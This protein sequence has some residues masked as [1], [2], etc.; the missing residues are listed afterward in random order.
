MSLY[1]M[2]KAALIGL[3]KALAREL[4]A[5]RITVNLV[6][7]G[8]VDTDMN[9]AGGPHAEPQRALMS[10]QEYGKAEDIAATV[11]WLAGTEGG[12]VTGATIAVDGGI[13]A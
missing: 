2:S 12:Y 9:P 11:A 7:P 4:G 5:N 1:S 13:N 3:T 6:Q 10:I 8:P